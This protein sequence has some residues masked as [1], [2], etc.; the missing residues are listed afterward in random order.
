MDYLKISSMEK[1][2]VSSASVY[3]IDDSQI[4]EP[5][6]FASGAPKHF[7]RREGKE[8]TDADWPGLKSIIHRLY[9]IENLTFPKVKETLHLELGYNIT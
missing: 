5:R 3:G 7:P 9:I 8:I 1:R 2:K 4:P 6:C